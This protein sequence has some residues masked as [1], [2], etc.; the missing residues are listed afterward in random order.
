MTCNMSSQG[1]CKQERLCFMIAP[2][3]RGEGEL[4]SSLPQDA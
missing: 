1:V 4:T 3:A 2:Q